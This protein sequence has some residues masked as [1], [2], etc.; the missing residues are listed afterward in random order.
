ML[1]DFIEDTAKE[2]S[3]IN[4]DD[5]KSYENLKGY[6]HQTVRHTVGEYVDGKIHINSTESFWL[7]L[8]RAQKGTYYKLSK[9][10]LNRYV[11]E[12]AGRHNIREKDTIDQM[13]KVVTGMVG[14][15]LKYKELIGCTDG[16]LY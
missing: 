1:H 10:H 9:K 11:D 8:K 14:K 7:M 3:T 13:R 15:R 4:T 6:D 2:G 5:F 12:F 16:R